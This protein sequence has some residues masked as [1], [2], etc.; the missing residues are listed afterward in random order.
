MERAGCE[1]ALGGAIALGFWSQPRGTVDVDITLFLPPEQPTGF[2]RL[3]QSVGCQ[4]HADQAV[5][6]LMQHGFCQVEFEGRRVDAFLPTMPF[7]ELA[8]QRR[9]QVLLGTQPIM[10]WDAETL[11]VFKMMF[12]RRKDL[13]DIEQMLQLQHSLDRTWILN[14][15][16]QIYGA[17]DPRI[18]QWKELTSEPS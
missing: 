1:Y 7:Y 18:A 16:T 2:V 9:Q 13:A 3:L 4:L 6:S 11:C 10:I 12:F 15:I 17:R 8:R 14:Q 5:Q